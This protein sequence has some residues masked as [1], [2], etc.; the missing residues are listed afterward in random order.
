[1]SCFHCFCNVSVM[2]CWEQVLGLPTPTV[3][4]P[5]VQGNTYLSYPSL[6]SLSCVAKA[7]A[8]T[9]LKVELSLKNVLYLKKVR[10]NHDSWLRFEPLY[11]FFPPSLC[12][13]KIKI[14]PPIAPFIPCLGIF[15]RLPSIFFFS[16]SFSCPITL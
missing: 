12:T 8:T 6:Q 15:S 4:L 10:G 11:C 16:L 7:T 2:L 13:I 1:M 14:P 5:Y 3:Q 9:L